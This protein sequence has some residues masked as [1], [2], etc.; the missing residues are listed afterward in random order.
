MKKKKMC[1]KST[2]YVSSEMSDDH[3][4]YGKGFN[5]T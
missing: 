4:V 3:E 1:I 5:G 2:I